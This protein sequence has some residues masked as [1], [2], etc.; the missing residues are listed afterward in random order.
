[1]TK[2]LPID[3]ALIGP[4]ATASARLRE[5]HVLPV[6]VDANVLIEDAL[7]RL[8]RPGF[9][10]SSADRPVVPHVA[11]SALSHLMAIHAI[12]VYGKPD[13]LE[14]VAAHIPRVAAR[15][16]HDPSLALALFD[17]EYVPYLRLVDPAGI[18]IPDSE[19]AFAQWR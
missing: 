18:V 16:G 14:E 5:R 12:R 11:A 8:A 13:L 1:M 19:A 3:V 10:A 2:P 15:K 7:H 9:I 4:T 6:V 17:A